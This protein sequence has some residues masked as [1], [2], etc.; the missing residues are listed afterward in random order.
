MSLI[1]PRCFWTQ[2]P[3][4][5]S[6]LECFSSENWGAVDP[7]SDAR[8]LCVVKMAS[9]GVGGALGGACADLGDQLAPAP[10]PAL[11]P[12]RCPVGSCGRELENT[13]P[14]QPGPRGPLQ[15]RPRPFPVLRFVSEATVHR[16]SSYRDGGSVSGIRWAE[17]LD[18][19]IQSIFHL[20][21]VC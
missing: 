15:H 4:A 9:A 11:P 2:R 18:L 5:C 6:V 1:G 21:R 7:G 14:S 8:W 16:L 17:V 13:P 10:F 19:V 3:E 20:T 12:D